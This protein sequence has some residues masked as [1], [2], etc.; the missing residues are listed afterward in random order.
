MTPYSSRPV[1][2]MA[3]HTL[4]QAQTISPLYAGDAAPL[5]E[6]QL[7]DLIRQSGCRVHVYS[8]Q[9]RL[10]AYA[11][12]FGGEPLIGLN[13]N[14]S[15]LQRALGARHELHHVLA[16]EVNNPIAPMFMAETGWMAES[17]RAA[18]LFA[19]TDLVPSW[20][21]RRHR[22]GTEIAREVTQAVAEYAEGLPDGWTADRA[23]LRLL[24]FREHGF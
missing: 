20:T 7:T 14:A 19:L 18:D 2:N 5:H 8:F 3:R 10:A 15:G 6:G 9:S 21:L 22:S 12:A 23:R 16:G 13:A 1:L 11:F 24:L 17:E 4:E